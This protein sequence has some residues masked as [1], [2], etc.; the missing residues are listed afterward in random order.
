MTRKRK[1]AKHTEKTI[2]SPLRRHKDGFGVHTICLGED[3][4][5]CNS[6]GGLWLCALPL[7][8]GTRKMRTTRRTFSS[9]EMA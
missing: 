2:F 9:F 7:A 5:Y 4:R 1:E 8:G 3:L 6:L